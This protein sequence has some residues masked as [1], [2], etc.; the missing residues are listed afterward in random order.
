MTGH[1]VA[2]ALLMTTAR[3]LIR[4]LSTKPQ[5]LSECI[6]QVNGLLVSDVRDSGNFMSLFVLLLEPG[7]R[8]V[9]WPGLVLGV[10]EEYS[11]EQLERTVDPPGT[12]IVMATDGIWEAHNADGEM[13]GKERLKDVIR[14]NANRTAGE[15]QDA[16]F[17]A[18][19]DFC[20]HIAQED[21]VTV[22][23]VKVL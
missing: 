17:R 10:D 15:I 19:S 6:T 12:V 18:L 16:A 23:V 4:G 2:S 22:V 1:G 3:A 5:T 21:D 8:T 20:G 7:S 11:Y 9:N 13:F 14:N